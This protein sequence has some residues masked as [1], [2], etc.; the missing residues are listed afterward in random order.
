MDSLVAHYTAN[1]KRR[2]Q[3]AYSHGGE[4]GCRPDR[5]IITY[6]A[7]IREAWKDVSIIIGGIEASLRRYAHYDYW[8]D[9]VRRSVLLDSK[10]DILVYGMGEKPILE[11]AQRLAAGE[12]L[13]GIRGACWRTGKA[14]DVP[15]EAALLPSFEDVSARTEEGKA[16]FARSY[17]IQEQNACPVT[18]G[19]LAERSG[20]QFVVHERPAEPLTTAEFDQVMELPYARRWHPRY[21]APAS[22]GKRGIPALQEVLFSLVSVRGCFGSCAFCAIA[23]HQGRRIQARSHK[24]LIREATALTKHPD[25]KGYI[26]D[27]GGPTANF[28]LPPC[29]KQERA[30]CCAGQ[31]CLGATPCPS[32]T[33]DHRDYIALLRKLRVIPGVKKVFVRSGI[34]FDYVMLDKDPAF[35]R[36]L[37]EYH[38]SGQLKVAPEQVSDRVL[39]LMRK[40]SHTV[41]DAFAAAYAKTNRVLGKKQYLVP[42]YIASLPGAG[43]REAAEAALYLKE[44]GFVPDQVQDFYP[45]PGSLATCMY[46]T[47]LDPH[48]GKAVYAARG[49]RERRL[50]RALLQFNKPENAALVREALTKAGLPADLL[51]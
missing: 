9:T 31:D 24:S 35:L 23:F 38:V 50:Q 19:V 12:G 34:R 7:K 15:A 25:F 46:Y 43:L 6:C 48:T 30:G 32:L 40:S 5:A 22:N 3:D 51:K 8:S 18:G 36:E 44:T 42:Y 10:A 11:I 33:V 28:R 29:E 47:G 2:S 27:V 13:R 16:A 45:T 1:K 20:S 39:A 41:Y 26:H 37:C 49:E 4:A 14:G 17:L 21:D